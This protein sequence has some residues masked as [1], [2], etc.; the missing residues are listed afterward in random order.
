MAEKVNLK[1]KAVNN[2]GKTS[3]R[4]PSRQHCHTVS[5]SIWAAQSKGECKGSEQKPKTVNKNIYKYGS[6]NF[7]VF[8]FSHFDLIMGS[9]DKSSV[10]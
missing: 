7:M 1:G 8:R 9:C 10:Q 3:I 4:V 2:S 5:F 6:S